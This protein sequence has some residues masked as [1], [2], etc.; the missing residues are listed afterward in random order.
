MSIT[1]RAGRPSRQPAPPLRARAP[2]SRPRGAVTALLL[3]FFGAGAGYLYLGRPWRALA[4]A[5]WTISGLTVWFG[6]WGRA[7]ASPT[8]AAALLG[9]A[10]A[11]IGL[12]AVDTA[13]LA[14]RSRAYALAWY[15]HAILYAAA[16]TASFLTG[17]LDILSGG[18]IGPAVR[19]F[20]VPSGSM[21]PGLAIGERFIADLW[22]YRGSAEPRRGDVIVFRHP[23][24]RQTV[25][26][27][28]VV[29]LPGERLQ[30][31]RGTLHI[32]GVPAPTV[33]AVEVAIQRDEPP[34]PRS[35]VTARRE[36]LPSGPAIVVL[37]LDPRSPG[38]DTPEIRVPPGHYFVLGDNRDNSA[39]SRLA[40]D[41]GGTGPIPRA[42]IDGRAAWIYW[43]SVPGRLFL[44]L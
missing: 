30:M 14:R 38:D 29:G 42:L 19:S 3:N 20:H 36:Q 15:N 23:R 21:E 31:I 1:R 27:K 28:R 33:D 44:R 34:A 26:V 9:L 39:D 2:R 18:R 22:A 5:A 43:S 6:P 4:L 25:Y 12:M 10:L 8:G 13:L 35:Q 11:G 24:E 37:D 17:S 40:L 16:V 32:D 41:R 7:L